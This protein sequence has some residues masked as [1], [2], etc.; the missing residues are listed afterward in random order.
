MPTAL[1]TGASAGLGEEFAQQLA[2]RGYDLVLVARDTDRLEE[3]AGRLR[4]HRGVAVEVLSADLADRDELGRVAARVA[5][6]DRPVE[7]LVNNAGFGL[8]QGLLGGDLAE[9]ETALDVMVRAVL[10]LTHAA[11]NRMAPAGEGAVLNVS[12]VASWATMGTYSAIKAWVT[13][14]SEGLARELA[15]HGVRVSAVCPGFVHTEFH[16]RARISKEMV[17][18]P[19]WLTADRVVAEALADLERGRPVSVPSRRY[20]AVVRLLRHAPRRLV[21]RG[22]AGMSRRRGTGSP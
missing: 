6:P 2:A 4:E 7:L 14:F 8:R 3:L 18:D 10:V 5:D 17:P 9:Q 13:V 15:D 21:R 22:S 12:S 19:M 16:A 1:V 20:Q 11:V